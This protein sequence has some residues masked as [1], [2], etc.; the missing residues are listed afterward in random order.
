MQK[1]LGTISW[2]RPYVGL[3]ISQL[4]LLF[5]ILKND[6]HLNSPRKLTPG[7]KAALEIEQAVTNRQVHQKYPE[8]CITVFIFSVGFHP[9]AIIGQWGTQW[10]DPLHVLEW[11]FLPINLKR[12]HLPSLS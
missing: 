8:V 5:N 6:P 1:L 3:T 12:R 7:A 4:G 10:S 2:L 9:T 11:V